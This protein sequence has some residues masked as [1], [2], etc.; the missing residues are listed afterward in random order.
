[1]KPGLNATFSIAEISGTAGEVTAPG[2]KPERVLEGEPGHILGPG[3]ID[4]ALWVTTF[5]CIHN[6]AHPAP[7]TRSPA[8]GHGTRQPPDDDR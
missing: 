1:M 7:R 5:G 4:P 2:L 3:L 8:P 6:M